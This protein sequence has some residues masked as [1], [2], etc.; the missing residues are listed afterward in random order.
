MDDFC[1]KGFFSHL[2]ICGSVS[3]L[4]FLGP[5]NG[6]CLGEKLLELCKATAHP[7]MQNDHSFEKVNSV[8]CPSPASPFLCVSLLS[9]HRFPALFSR[10]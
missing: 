9:A 7:E 5:C 3:V 4:W 1:R 2:H 6:N 8:A 10:R